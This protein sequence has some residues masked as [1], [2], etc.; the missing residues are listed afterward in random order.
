MIDFRNREY[1]AAN[2]TTVAA[3]VALTAGLIWQWIPKPS[4]PNL[5]R[6]ARKEALQ[7][8][9]QKKTVDGQLDAAKA[10]VNQMTW[11]GETQQINKTILDRIN[12]LI[13]KDGLNLTSIRPQRPSTIDDLDTLPYLVIVDG[14]YPQLV[15]FA[16]DL[17]VPANKLATNL[18]QIS[19]AETTSG[20][21]TANIAVVAYLNPKPV[22]KTLTKEDSTTRA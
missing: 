7:V 11:T 19:T 12:A 2:L 1:L 6:E 14:T 18:I 8:L 5:D 4:N 21:V 17:D 20:R 3:V 9:E 16:R 15:Q 13:K 10:Y 22:G